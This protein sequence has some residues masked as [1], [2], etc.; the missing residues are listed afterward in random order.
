MTQEMKKPPAA[1][2]A[3]GF[4]NLFCL[5]ANRAES[6]PEPPTFQDR[7][8]AWVARRYAVPASLAQTI[9]AL[10]FEESWS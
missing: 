9:A 2:F 4:Q 10:A 7:R 6:N 5:E 1:G 3:G 8:A